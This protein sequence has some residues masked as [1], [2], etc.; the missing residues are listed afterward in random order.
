MILAISSSHLNFCQRE[1]PRSMLSVPSSIFSVS[2]AVGR[3]LLSF[4]AVGTETNSAIRLRIVPRLGPDRIDIAP[5]PMRPATIRATSV[6]VSRDSQTRS[7]T[8][9]W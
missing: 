6:I 4:T 2:C 3:R 5:R 9:L 1:L 8:R 7:K